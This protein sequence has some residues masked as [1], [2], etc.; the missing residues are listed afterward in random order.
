VS[1]LDWDA[2]TH[3]ITT[4]SLH[5]FEENKAV[6]AGRTVFPRAPHLL[7]D[8]QARLLLLNC[9]GICKGMA[10]E[11]R[12]EATAAVNESKPTVRCGD[13]GDVRLCCCKAAWQCSPR[14]S[15]MCWTT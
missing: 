5:S 10:A 9:A 7:A 6:L 13:R 15:W 14:W 1:V 2:A 4:T 8:P 3:S 11:T 12:S